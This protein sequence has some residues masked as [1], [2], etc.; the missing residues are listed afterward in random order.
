MIDHSDN[1]DLDDVDD[2]SWQNMQ[3]ERDMWESRAG[4]AE[5]E[6]SAL[7]AAARAYVDAT[8]SDLEPDDPRWQLVDGL[9][10]L[11][12]PQRGL[13]KASMPSPSPQDRSSPSEPTSRG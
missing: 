12:T 3:D 1:D 6:L 8:E 5:R 9:A 11:T 13:R 7:R 2:D 10:A 4:V